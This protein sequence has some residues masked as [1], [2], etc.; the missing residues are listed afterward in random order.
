MEDDWAVL[1]EE[2]EPAEAAETEEAE[3]E[4]TVPV[5]E[6]TEADFFE[7]EV[8]EETEAELNAG[9]SGNLPRMVFWEFDENGLLR[10]YGTGEMLICDA[11]SQVPWDDLRDSITAIR[12]DEGVTSLCAYAFYGCSAL[13][14]IDLAESV[15]TIGAFVFKDCGGP[16]TVTLG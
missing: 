16:Q 2:A 13:S 9:E 6:E 1:E 8:P 11:P 10:I 3:T 5:E 4:E 14:D 15:E 12:V 7:E